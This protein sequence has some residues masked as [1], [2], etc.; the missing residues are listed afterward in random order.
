MSKTEQITEGDDLRAAKSQSEAMGKATIDL[1]AAAIISVSQIP[2]ARVVSIAPSV[3]GGEAVA[4][5]TL[6]D[7]QQFKT[8]EQPLF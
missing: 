6:L 2:G 4:S 3:K 1:K 8:V 7:G 5:I